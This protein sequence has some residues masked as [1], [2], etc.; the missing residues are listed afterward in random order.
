M[1]LIYEYMAHSWGFSKERLTSMELAASSKSADWI[2]MAQDKA[3]RRGVLGTIMSLL[4][5]YVGREFVAQMSSC[6]ITNENSDL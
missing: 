5:P 3:Q 6:Q 4:V 2:Q 1:N